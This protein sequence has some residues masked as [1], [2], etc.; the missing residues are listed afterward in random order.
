MH[1]EATTP[2]LHALGGALASHHA[3]WAGVVLEP[4]PDKGLAHAHLRL[5]G[6]GLLARVPKQSQLGLPAAQHLAYEAACF[7]RA[8]ASGHT[9]RVHVVIAPSVDLPH[10]ALVVDEI[11]GRAARL[12]QDLPALVDALAAIHNL[13][14]PPVAARAPLIDP[15][16]TLAAL[17]DEIAGQARH[18]GAA[19]LG[20]AVR[21]RIDAERYALARRCDAP[22]RPRRALI[23]FDGHPG[24]F[25][26]DGT[27]RAW[28][29]D[30]EKARYSHP[31]L[32]LA[33]ATLYTSTTW[34]LDSRAVLAFDEVRAACERWSDRVGADAAERRWIV[35][36]RRA[37]WLWSVTWCAKWR[38]LSSRAPHEATGGEDW[39]SALSQDALVAH[40]R[41]RVDHYLSAAVVAGVCDEADALERALERVA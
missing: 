38:A 39:S 6:T 23:A 33:H 35:P 28:L 17:R 5:R 16:D 21:A 30:L 22:A 40:V 1:A 13:P 2:L 34:D 4:L 11:V 9:P 7:G 29:V 18:L 32:D 3:P 27:G 15:L 10:G 41:D 36:L 24:N 25:I 12:P 8:Q 14:L 37:M 26:V 20:P 31:A 19:G